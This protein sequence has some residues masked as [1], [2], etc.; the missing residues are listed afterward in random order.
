MTQEFRRYFF[1]QLEKKSQ[2]PK[3]MAQILADELGISL[4]SA[5]KKINGDAKI[6]LEEAFTLAN[7]YHLSL[8][9]VQSQQG[10][11]VMFHYPS[12]DGEVMSPWRFLDQLIGM[13]TMLRASP[14][15]NIRHTTCEL[16]LFHYIFFPGLTAVK[17]YFYSNS[18][19]NLMGNE[20]P[21]QVWIDELLANPAFQEKCWQ[22]F[23]MAAASPTEEY[24][25]VTM[26]DTTLRQ[27]HF[28]RETGQIS[29][30]FAATAFKQLLEMTNMISNWANEG[31]KRLSNGQPG[32]SYDL[33]VNEL[34]YTNIMFLIENQSGRT[35]FST[36]DSPN[37]TICRDARVLDRMESW[38]NRLKNKSS[39]ISGQNEK[40][41]QVFLQDVQ[42][43]VY[44]CQQRKVT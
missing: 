28:L 6:T 30:S 22:V 31:K 13:L 11:G 25:Q 12:L 40:Q 9:L 1:S 19:W 23:D 35:L 39:Q 5:Y 10:D 32:A 3:N 34:V 18:V 44:E 43:R 8:D 27:I 24:Y 36:L 37:F 20:R 16:P 38:F 21:G 2:S 41:R 17:F 7:K 4:S 42:L 14:G 33:H 29:E 15:I 26:Y